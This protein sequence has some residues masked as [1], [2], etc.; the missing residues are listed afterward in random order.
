MPLSAA[1]SVCQARA[2]TPRNDCSGGRRGTG[3][4]MRRERRQARPCKDP[5]AA[6][7]AQVLC[8]PGSLGALS[9]GCGLVPARA[10][11][12]IWVPSWKLS[13]VATGMGVTLTGLQTLVSPL[14]N[15]EFRFP[16]QQSREITSSLQRGRGAATLSGGSREEPAWHTAGAKTTGG[17]MCIE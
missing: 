13:V 10:E 9:Q 8:Q 1:L 16:D 15:P 12:S 11:G 2:W 6:R 5:R 7:H 17:C 14:V 4:K 3:Q